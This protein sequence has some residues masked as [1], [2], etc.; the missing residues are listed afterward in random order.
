MRTYNCDATSPSRDESTT[1]AA[2][3][4]PRT[5]VFL[6]LPY[7]LYTTIAKNCTFE[8]MPRA[9]QIERDWNV[10]R[11]ILFIDLWKAT[12][13]ITIILSQ[14]CT[15]A[16]FTYCVSHSRRARDTHTCGFHTN[17]K[18]VRTTHNRPDP[19]KT[20]LL[21]ANRYQSAGQR[22]LRTI[23]IILLSYRFINAFKKTAVYTQ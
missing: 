21:N 23:V 20:A 5:R 7:T 14:R 3:G 10:A 9:R 1:S 2:V 18:R 4:T 6:Y 8:C 17:V 12:R 13:A 16:A 11:F 19:T 15:F 22:V